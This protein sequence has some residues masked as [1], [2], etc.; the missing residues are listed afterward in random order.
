[1]VDVLAGLVAVD[2]LVLA[3]VSSARV[4]PS[5]RSSSAMTVADFDWRVDFAADE[6]APLLVGL[7][8]VVSVWMSGAIAAPTSLS[9]VRSHRQGKR[10]IL[11]AAIQDVIAVCS[12]GERS[13]MDCAL[14]TQNASETKRVDARGRIDEQLRCGTWFTVLRH[15]FGRRVPRRGH[16]SKCGDC[17]G[18]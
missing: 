11:A 6:G 16:V 10:R 13:R 9:P 17:D 14:P 2:L 1:M 15:V 3:A 12:L 5:L 8:M 7:C 18:L 4:A